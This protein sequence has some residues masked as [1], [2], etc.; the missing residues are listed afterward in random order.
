MYKI[1]LIED[2]PVISQA[3]ENHLT[4]W[5]YR[6]MAEKD[7]Q[8]VLEDFLEF[9]PHLV[10][11]DLSLPFQNG[12]LWCEKIRES[13]KVPILFL[14]SAGSR[15]NIVTAVNLGGDDFIA[16][17]FDLSVLT[18]KI[19]AVLRRTYSFP[20]ASDSLKHKG[21]LLDLGD[22]SLHYEGKK[23]ELTKNELR[24]LKILLE[25]AGHTVPRRELM[26][27][28]WES[29]SFIDGNTLTVSMTR[30]RKKL[31]E[32]GLKDFIVTQKGLGYLIQ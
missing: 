5:G 16:K 27:R 18:A 25:N 8:R 24:I 6:V 12:F 22:A 26:Q 17:P 21:V 23:L 19:Q 28:L 7:F 30:L 1:F 3:V 9:S 31:S 15:E 13:S 11:L 4:M 14:S 29:E 2:D 10:I 20:N 32:L